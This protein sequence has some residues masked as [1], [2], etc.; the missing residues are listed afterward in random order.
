MEIGIETAM[1]SVAEVLRRNASST[2]TARTPPHTAEF[3][4]LLIDA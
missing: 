4:T 3:L 1:I 2:T